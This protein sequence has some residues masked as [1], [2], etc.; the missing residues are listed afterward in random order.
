MRS[1]EELR[2]EIFRR[3]ERKRMATRRLYRRMGTLG[4]LLCL[5]GAATLW[6]M[7]GPLHREEGKKEPVSFVSREESHTVEHPGGNVQDDLTPPSEQQSEEQ[8]SSPV[9]GEMSEDFDASQPSAEEPNE[10]L[11]QESPADLPEYHPEGDS[12]SSEPEEEGDAPQETPLPTVVLLSLP[13][14]T[15]PQIRFLCTVQGV[16]TREDKEFCP[17]D[18]LEVQMPGNTMA[19]ASEGLLAMGEW[20]GDVFVIRDYDDCYFLKGA[21]GDEGPG[22]SS[23][24]GPGAPAGPDWDMPDQD[25]TAPEDSLS[26]FDL[27]IFNAGLSVPN[28]RLSV[29]EGEKLFEA[30]KALYQ[31]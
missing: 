15:E 25:P 17:G 16:L 14:H 1:T 30:L 22:D 18:T 23:A 21:M 5:C 28:E 8:E 9:T 20:Q 29:E 24:E 12:D 19:S 7:L 26:G 3:A 4:L 11:S 27:M 10:E 31:P 6:G 2:R 13:A